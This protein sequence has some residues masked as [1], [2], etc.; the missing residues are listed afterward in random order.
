MTKRKPSKYDHFHEKTYISTFVPTLGAD[1]FV[2]WERS[3]I[4]YQVPEPVA[5]PGPRTGSLSLR[6]T[7]TPRETKDKWAHVHSVI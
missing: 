6:S 7:Y 2:W 1:Y 5:P 3:G 4:P